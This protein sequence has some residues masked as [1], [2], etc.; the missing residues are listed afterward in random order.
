M[1]EHVDTA[2]IT[3]K[4]QTCGQCG[5]PFDPHV[6]VAVNG[7]PTLG[8]IILCPQAECRCYATYGFGRNSERPMVALTQDELDDLH[9]AV[10]TGEMA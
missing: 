9:H 2:S 3:E 4:G 6:L 10:W 7:D 1:A 8:G 5:H